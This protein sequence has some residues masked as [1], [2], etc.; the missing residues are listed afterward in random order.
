MKVGV[1]TEIKTDEYRVAL[2]PAGV[3]EL[4]ERGHEVVVQQGAGE[5]SAIADDEY[6]AQGAAIV[7][8]A[9]AVFARPSMIVKVKEPQPVEVAR[10]RAAPHAL[11]LPAPG[12][13]PRADAAGWSSR[14]AT[15]IAYETVEDA[16]GRLP[17]LAPMSEVAGKIAT[18]AGRVHA[19]EAARRPRAAARRRAGRRGRQGD[20]HRRRRGRPERGG[21]RDRHG[22][23][24]LRLRPLHRPPA[25]AGVPAQRPLLDRATPR[26]WRSSSGCPRSTSSSARCSSTGAKAPHVDH[27]RAARADEAQRRARRRLDRPGRLL[28]DLA[29]R[30]RT[31]TRPTRSTAS[32]TTAWPTCPARC[33]SRRTCALTNA[34]MPYVIK[35][36]DQGVAGRAR[37]ATRASCRASTSPR[38]RSPTRRWPS[39]QGLEYTARRRGAR[40]WPPALA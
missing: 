28:R 32:R 37:R 17:L 27:A 11:H 29:R 7:P 22:R 1:P 23:R 8:D 10:L 19:R 24:D 2:T 31:P 30:R 40:A 16:R 14:G 18:Q 34:T 25:R 21:D 20:G 33:R 36:A 15:C 6:V 35:L 39:D 4:T 13:R 3:R 12:A 5:G 26:R 9:D 38:A